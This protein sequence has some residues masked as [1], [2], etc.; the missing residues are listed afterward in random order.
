MQIKPTKIQAFIAGLC[1]ILSSSLPLQA[2]TVFPIADRSTVVQVCDGVA[3]DGSNYLAALSAGTEVG[4]QLFSPAGTLIG[5]LVNV[6]SSSA[7]PPALTADFGGGAFLEVWS[8]N[9][10]KSGVDMFGQRISTAGAKLGPRFPLLSSAGAYGFQTVC[11]LGFGGGNFLVVWRDGTSGD[12]Y[13][14]IVTGAGG[15]SGPEFLI[16]DQ[17][18]NGKSASVAFDGTNFLVVWQ[19]NNNTTGDDNETYGAFISSGGSAG[20]PFQISQTDSLDQNPLTVAFDG[21]N[22]LVVWSKDTQVNANDVV[23]DWTLYGRFVSPGGALSANEVVLEGYPGNQDF[24]NLAF[25]GQNYLLV[26]SAYT[27]GLSAASLLG[28][29]LDRSANAVG[30]TFATLPPMGKNYPLLAVNGLL[31]DGTQFVLAGLSGIETRNASGDL[32]G[33]AAGQVW[34]VFIPTSQTSPKIVTEPS[35][36]TNLAGTTATLTVAVE[37]PDLSYQWFKNGANLAAS[38]RISGVNSDSL[39]ISNLALSEAGT[40]SVVASNLFGAAIS[41]NVTLTIVTPVTITTKSSPLTGATLTGGG[42]YTGDSMVTVTAT[43][44]NECYYFTNWTAS[45]KVVSTDSTYMFTAVKSETLT[46]NFLPFLYEVQT[47]SAP[48]NGGTTGGGGA[49]DCGSA[50]TV[51]AHAHTGFRFENWMEGGVVV[52][53]SAT[54]KFTA[55]ANVQL[56]ANFINGTPPT[57]TLTSPTASET[58]TNGTLTVSGKAFDSVA[59]ADVFYSVSGSGWLSAQNNGGWT[60]WTFTTALALGTNVIQ[61]YAQDSAGLMSTIKTLTVVRELTPTGFSIDATDPIEHPQA[62]IAFD[63]A[64]YL[65]AFQIGPFDNSHDVAQFVSQSGQLVGGL[66]QLNPGRNGDPP[67]VAFD[68]KNYLT[69]W[70]DYSDTHSNARSS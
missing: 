57:L 56:T 62:Q 35:S 44:T 4:A 51:T 19:S 12:F 28:Q 45:G 70:A 53:T 29:F 41:S 65:V 52:S 25:D 1:A 48:A 42:P 37:G 40:Y 8:D 26:W 30:P 15:L 64:N 24:P 50:V 59:V 68:G 49:K 16:S 33:F 43:V 55:G 32:T 63:G 61:I 54:Y 46:A 47:V 67:S 6:G 39:T 17:P 69:A 18:Q 31:Y 20:S 9:S 13:G 27:N 34:G 38:T 11:A 66:L 14:Q 5:S 10:I 36:T 22:Y 3:Y 7:F 58:T 23:L 60:N 21:T 2:A